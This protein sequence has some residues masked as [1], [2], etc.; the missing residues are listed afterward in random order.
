MSER[1]KSIIPMENMSD[2]L[3]GQAKII[4]FPKTLRLLKIL[5]TNVSNERAKTGCDLSEDYIMSETKITQVMMDDKTIDA[6]KK[7]QWCSPCKHFV[8][9]RADIKII[10]PS[11]ATFG[12]C[13]TEEER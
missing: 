9:L 5:V 1:R 6:S 10:I 7:L 8:A 3:R 2:L 11:S 13:I 12:V 4:I